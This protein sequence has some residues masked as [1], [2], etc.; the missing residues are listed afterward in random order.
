VGVTPKTNFNMDAAKITKKKTKDKNLNKLSVI[1]NVLLPLHEKCGTFR[2]ET[3]F[4][5]DEWDFFRDGVRQTID[6]NPALVQDK[7]LL[8]QQ[9]NIILDE[10][11]LN[12]VKDENM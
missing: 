4:S 11:L 5:I 1:D 9:L 7:A 8:V 3:V 6:N 2:K 10:I 12:V